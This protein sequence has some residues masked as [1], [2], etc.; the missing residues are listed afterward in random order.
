MAVTTFAAIDVGSNEV[1]LK[2][3]ELGKKNQMKEL[4][5]V[6]HIMELGSDTYVSGY[7][8][9]HLI[10]E[11][12]DVLDGF[13]KIMKEFQVTEYRA[14]STSSIR[15][16]AN[17]Q[18]LLDRVR[19]RTGIDV[20]ILTNSEQRYLLYQAVA[21]REPA[22][23]SIIK[24]G[25]MLVEVGSGSSQATC[26]SGGKLVVS[27]NLRLGSIRL[28]EFLSTLE[29]EADSYADL[30]SEYIDG[31]IYTSYKTY[32]HKYR[33]RSIL[34]IGEE[35]RDLEQYIKINLQQNDSS[36]VK[37]TSEELTTIYNSILT[38]SN[39]EIA[40]MLG[41]TDEQAR[42]L[43]PTAMIYEKLMSIN[44]ADTI[45][46][47]STDLCDG[48]VV[49]YA[50]DNNRLS[51]VRDFDKDVLSAA[52]KLAIRYSSNTIHTTYVEKLAGKIFEGLSHISGLNKHDKLL[53][54]VAVRLHDCGAYINFEEVAAN[55]YNI[56]RSSEILGLTDKDN[57]MI[58][59]IVMN[60]VKSFP[61]YSELKNDFTEKEYIKIAKL[62]GIFRLA[63]DL[64]TSKKQKLSH[65]KVTLKNNTLQI[66][67]E[68][69]MDL[70]L[71]TAYFN[72]SARFFERI[73]GIVPK[74][75]Q[76]RINNVSDL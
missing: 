52:K 50:L 19:I 62:T 35:L 49:Q 18:S 13:R 9:N 51:K 21:L 11:L 25:A 45:Y 67:G 29:R 55:S 6:R 30:L 54:L 74:L 4:T 15:E 26:F 20:N 59:N 24:H 2:I 22:F 28:S 10:D 17:R 12:C 71:E 68:S 40:T 76:R 27:H 32:F 38:H 53:L 69:F 46:F 5:H 47:N 44:K 8:S 16:A 41:T 75:K 61:S 36:A 64:D 56:I 34:A 70:A 39:S 60:P 73:F 3:F 42:L 33:I 31:D 37:I 57:L 14:Y 43:L 1:S 65:L 7:I 23:N 58:A 66:T 63:N 72:E 48:I